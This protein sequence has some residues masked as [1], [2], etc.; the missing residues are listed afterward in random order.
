DFLE[1]LIQ[2]VNPYAQSLLSGVTPAHAAS[3]TTANVTLSPH[4]E[5]PYHSLALAITD[6]A[7]ETPPVEVKLTNVQLFDLMEAV[8]QLLADSQTLPDLTLALTPLARRETQA[9]VPLAQQAA[10]IAI[11]TSGLAAAAALLF[12]LPVP[13][14]KPIRVEGS[15]TQEEASTPTSSADPGSSSDATPNA[16]NTDL[17]ISDET[18]AASRT[19]ARLSTAPEITDQETLEQLQADLAEALE[20]DWT[21]PDDLAVPLTYEVAVSEAGDLLGYRHEDN[22]SLLNVESTPLP[23][24]T[25]TLLDIEAVAEEPVAQFEITLDPDGTVTV[26]PMPAANEDN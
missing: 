10:P 18:A 11:G 17:E 6:K 19:L 3:K 1:G 7:G 20:A 12:F 13:E 4:G 15:P 14:L 21:A 22:V 23:E 8:D 5:G 9:Q 2:A 25:Y 26:E 24:L 16:D